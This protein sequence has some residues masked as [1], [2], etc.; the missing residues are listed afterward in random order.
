M[1]RISFLMPTFNR[2][3]LI[4]ESIASVTSQMSADDELILIDDGSNDDTPEVLKRVTGDHRIIAQENSGKAVALNR[5]LSE[6]QGK[7]I[8]ICDDDDLLREGCVRLMVAA[9]NKPNT[10]MVFA[11]YTRFAEVDGERRDMGTG[12]WPDLSK[13]SI[14]R[15]VLEDSFVMQNATLA[16]REA[17]AKVGSFDETLLRSLDYDMAVRLATQVR[18]RYVD[19]IA[20]DQRKHDGARGPASI[21]H[22]AGSSESVWLD[23]DRRIFERQR[24]IIPLSFYQSMFT[25]TDPRLRKRAALLQRACVSARHDMWSDAVNDLRAASALAPTVAIGSVERDICRRAVCGKHGFPGAL[26]DEIVARLRNLEGEGG[27]ATEIVETVLRGTLWRLRDDDK[28]MRQSAKDL[29]T[30]VIGL[31]G[32]A[33]LSASHLVSKMGSESDNGIAE[34]REI[35]PLIVANQQDRKSD[36]P[37]DASLAGR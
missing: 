4:E 17:Y 19:F 13:G 21:R 31:S 11:R 8:W 12:Y 10:D 3:H 7:F 27:N 5:G 30:G 16:T 1:T 37:A 14:A 29:I 15:H 35:E 6:A 20:F 24:Q 26:E 22:A 9:I 2:A 34:K 18:C 23:Y 36:L 25:H 32:L 33:R 28:A